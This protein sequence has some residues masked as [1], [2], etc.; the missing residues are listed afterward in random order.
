MFYTF[1]FHNVHQ[2]SLRQEFR[3]LWEFIDWSG[4]T[5]QLLLFAWISIERHILFSHDH[6]V[7]T[8]IK[9]F[10]FHYLPPIVIIVYD[11]LYYTLVIFTPN[12]KNIDPDSPNPTF[13][14]CAFQNEALHTS[15]AVVH[16][17]APIFIIL[18]A[19]V[20]VLIRILWQKYCVHQQIQWRQHRRMAVQLL[21]VLFLS[22]TFPTLYVLVFLLNICGITQTSAVDITKDRLY[23]GDYALLLH[24]VVCVVTLPGLSKKMKTFFPLRM[25]IHPA[26]PQQR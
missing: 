6:L 9:R 24:P 23:L 14:P 25:I 8:R 7:A 5:L 11:L 21:A 16:Q 20:I 22:L 4:L 12:C 18:I 19:G 13:D 10:F 17:I 1:Y 15:E 3:L 26:G 2:R